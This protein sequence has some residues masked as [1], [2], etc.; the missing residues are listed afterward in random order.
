MPIGKTLKELESWRAIIIRRQLRGK[1][2]RISDT[3]YTIFEKPRKAPAGTG[4][5]RYGFT[6]YGKPGYGKSRYG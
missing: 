4:T 2:G 6:R 1:N 3:E 5:A